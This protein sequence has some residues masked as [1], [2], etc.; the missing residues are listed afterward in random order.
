[1]LLIGNIRGDNESEVSE[2]EAVNEDANGTHKK[3]RMATP[4]TAQFAL[5]HASR[6]A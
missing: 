2:E 1:L 3:S 5:K 4:G 6:T